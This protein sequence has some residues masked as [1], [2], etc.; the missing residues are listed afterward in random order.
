MFCE[1]VDHTVQRKFLLRCA[2]AGEGLMEEGGLNLGPEE[3]AWFGWHGMGM[4]SGRSRASTQEQA[5][6]V[7]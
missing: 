5:A 6:C 7:K 3:W 4:G 2:G 1:V